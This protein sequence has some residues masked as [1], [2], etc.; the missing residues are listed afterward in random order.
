MRWYETLELTLLAVLL[1]TIPLDFSWSLWTLTALGA[2]LVAK[3]VAGPKRKAWRGDRVNL[4]LLLPI[5]YWLCYV[6]SMLWTADTA[7][8]WSEVAKLSSMPLVALYVLLSRQWGL[9]QLLTPMRLRLLLWTFTASLTAVF[10]VRLGITAHHVH[11]GMGS[12]HSLLFGSAFYHIHHSYLALYLLT[13]LAFLYTEALRWLKGESLNKALLGSAIVLCTATSVAFLVLTNSRAGILCVLIEG[14]ACLAHLF[15]VEKRR[16]ATLILVAVFA[17]AA[18]GT[19]VLL[20]ESQRR[21]SQTVSTM[22]ND[23]AEQDARININRNSIAEA[24]NALPFGVGAG[25]RMEVLSKHYPA[26]E[27][28]EAH[29]FNPHNQYV[30]CLLATGLIGLLLLLAMLALLLWTH[31]GYMLAVLFVIVMSVSLLFESLL[32]RQMGL[33]FFGTFYSLLALSPSTLPNTSYR[34]NIQ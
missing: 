13:A 24:F 25:D 9:Q 12:W 17:T 6:V 1:A 19:Y 32:E 30:D 33:I 15:L 26:T 31:R 16:V 5:A 14:V 11:Q 3:M 4:L 8:G 29:V 10:V 2:T 7:E 34:K 20:P 28:R 21:L 22:G 23:N 27:G 18:V